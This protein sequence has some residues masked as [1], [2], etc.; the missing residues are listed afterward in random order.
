MGHLV[1]HVL[2]TPT[3]GEKQLGDYIR[4]RAVNPD[5]HGSAFILTTESGSRREIFQIETEKARKLL[6]TSVL[7]NI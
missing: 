6:I 3:H 2:H 7:F 5:P 4:S 1:T